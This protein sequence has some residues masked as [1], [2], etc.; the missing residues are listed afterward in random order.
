[1]ATSSHTRIST[2]LTDV[3]RAPGG[4]RPFGTAEVEAMSRVVSPSA[5]R[6][7]GLALVTRCWR[8]RGRASIAIASQPRSRGRP[9]PVGPC[10][11]ATLVE[12]IKQAI[13]ESR[14][15]SGARTSGSEPLKSFRK[16]F[17]TPPDPFS[18]ISNPKSPT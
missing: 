10:D 13:A 2:T 1:M 18:F 14:F 17:C 3:I 4:W 9:G 15:V 12:H 6:V 8:S 7:Y 16:V 11:D 5:A